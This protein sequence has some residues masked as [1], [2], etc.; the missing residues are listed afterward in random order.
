MGGDWANRRLTAVKNT[1]KVG[2][3]TS[4]LMSGVE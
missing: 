4:Y 2:D 3:R 1:I